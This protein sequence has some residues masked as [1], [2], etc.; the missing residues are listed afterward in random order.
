MSPRSAYNRARRQRAYDSGDGRAGV[1]VDG[2][3]ARQLLLV[4]RVDMSLVRTT[5][6]ARG[7]GAPMIAACWRVGAGGGSA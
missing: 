7:V 4:M 1:V 3:V 5:H 6:V 2:Q